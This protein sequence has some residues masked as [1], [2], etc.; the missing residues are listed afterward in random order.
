M[1]KISSPLHIVFYGLIFFSILN[2]VD[3]QLVVQVNLGAGLIYFLIIFFFIVNFFTPVIRF[4]YVNLLSAWV[5]KV[6]KEFSRVQK[7]FSERMSDA[8][9]RVTQSIRV[10]S[11][12]V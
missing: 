2:A 3:A 5:L 6:G 9:K 12:K 4:M 11:S 10:E 8:G 7:R 1:N